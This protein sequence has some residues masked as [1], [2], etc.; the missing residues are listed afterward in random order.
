M[1]D[2]QH[3][4]SC[5]IL[6][7][8]ARAVNQISNAA[9][10]TIPFASQSSSRNYTSIRNVQLVVN[11]RAGISPEFI[12]QNTVSHILTGIDPVYSPNRPASGANPG[13]PAT[14]CSC[15]LRTGC[16]PG[17]IGRVT[18]TGLP[19]GSWPQLRSIHREPSGEYQR[20]FRKLTYPRVA[21]R[22][23]SSYS[24]GADA[25]VHRWECR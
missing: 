22:V 19:P 1:G 7:L 21:F 17:V 10:R 2:A 24:H 9:G 16:C 4:T 8:L 6:D 23:I 13:L 3:G 12:R 15:P 25:K 18:E 5:R 14:T 20:C 11:E